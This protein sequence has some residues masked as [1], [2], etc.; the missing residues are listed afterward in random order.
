[1]RCLVSERHKQAISSFNPDRIGWDVAAYRASIQSIYEQQYEVKESRRLEAVRVACEAVW[2]VMP[3]FPSVRRAYLFGSLVRPGDMQ[4]SADIDI[5]VEGSLTAT[6]FFALWRA[7]EEAAKGW[8]IDLVELKDHEVPTN[9]D[10]E[11][12][13]IVI[14]ERTN[15]D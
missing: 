13:G 12:R 3:R 11:E 7:L 8:D 14:Y 2:S 4:P 15:T 5:A 1:M 9:A 10:L 6:D